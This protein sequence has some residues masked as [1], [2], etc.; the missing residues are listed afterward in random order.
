[1]ASDS[2]IHGSARWP[3]H[4]NIIQPSKITYP[5][6]P[7]I[8]STASSSSDSVFSVDAPSSQSSA[9][10]DSW[11]S[12]SDRSSWISETEDAYFRSRD[13]ALQPTEELIPTII[14]SCSAYRTVN[15]A[16]PVTSESRQHPRRTQRLSSS[17]SQDGKTTVSCPRLPPSLVR[18]S[19]RKDNFVDSLVGKLT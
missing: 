5:Y 14:D 19:D 4:I 9:S 16:P 18:Q 13:T 11:S 7:S 12:S 2:D 6:S 8:A 17:D 15:L 1:M 10:S 3:H